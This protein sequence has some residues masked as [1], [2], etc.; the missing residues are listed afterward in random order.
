LKE[1]NKKEREEESG[2][3]K[4]GSEDGLRKSQEEIEK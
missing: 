3:N 1:R 4:E 2:N